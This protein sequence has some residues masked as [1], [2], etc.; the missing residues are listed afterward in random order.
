MDW[1]ARW[2]Y[3]DKNSETLE[4]FDLTCLFKWLLWAKIL[5]QKAQENRFSPVWATMWFL[6]WELNGAVLEQNGQAHW[7][8]SNLTGSIWNYQKMIFFISE[9]IFFTIGRYNNGLNVFVKNFL[10]WRSFGKIC[11]YICEKWHKSKYGFAIFVLFSSLWNSEDIAKNHFQVGLEHSVKLQENKMWEFEVKSFIPFFQYRF[12]NFK[13]WTVFT[14][15]LRLLFW[16]KQF[17]HWLQEYGLSPVWV[18]I[19]I[20]TWPGLHKTLEHCGQVLLST[21]CNFEEKRVILF[22]F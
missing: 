20:L 9:K 8:S 11:I 17:P 19:W 21:F 15:L 4:C 7:P 12:S 10:Y 3:W 16:L 5:S 6:M 13:E 14:C 18:K 22:H 1:D 2:F